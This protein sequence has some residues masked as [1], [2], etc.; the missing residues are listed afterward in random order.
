MVLVA[1]GNEYRGEVGPHF[2]GC[3]P[4]EEGNMQNPNRVLSGEE[5]LGLWRGSPDGIQVILH[6][7]WVQ[8]PM[9]FIPDHLLESLPAC[10]WKLTT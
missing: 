10:A 5:E 2:Q 7:S 4:T 6:Q 9:A 3:F 8:T 1:L